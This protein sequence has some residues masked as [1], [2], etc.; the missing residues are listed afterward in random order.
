MHVISRRV[1]V[2]CLDFLF[3]FTT[4]ELFC[5]IFDQ[6]TFWDRFIVRFSLCWISFLLSE[7]IRFFVKILWCDFITKTFWLYS[8]FFWYT[9]YYQYCEMCPRKIWRHQKLRKSMKFLPVYF[10]RDDEPIYTIYIY[11]NKWKLMLP[12]NKNQK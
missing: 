12:I 7:Q 11:E 3:F 9:F 4:L 5:K 8:C 6:E 2:W 10:G 1:C